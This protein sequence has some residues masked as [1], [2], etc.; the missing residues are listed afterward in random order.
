MVQQIKDPVRGT[1]IRKDDN[2]SKF[3]T[4]IFGNSAANGELKRS[5]EFLAE[6]YAAAN[7]IAANLS[8]HSKWIPYPF[9]VDHLKKISDEM[10]G[11]AEIFRAKIIELG[12][13]VPQS[14]LE[15]RLEMGKNR[16]GDDLHQNVK[17][18]VMDMEEHS[19]RCETLMHQKNIVHDAGGEKLLNAVIVDMQ[20]QKDELMDI[21]M[22]IS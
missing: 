14:G 2:R 3:F 13:Q 4:R 6:D 5:I 21:V 17:R 20:R 22:R 18:L 8:S 9:L 15:S 11:H 19:A 16:S 12:G 1:T 7:K 10:R